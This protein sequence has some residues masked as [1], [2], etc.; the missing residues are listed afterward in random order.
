MSAL[1]QYIELFTQHREAI[2]SHSTTAMNALRTKAL[3]VLQ[4]TTL[5]RKG[6]DDYEATDLEEVLSPDYGVN[7]NRVNFDA[8]PQHPFKCDVPNL[9]TCMSYFYNDIFHT[10]GVD[11]GDG[12]VV[13][14]LAQAAE[15]HPELLQKYYGTVAK[16][17]QPT[18]AL[19]TLLAQDGMLVYVPRG[20]EAKRTIQVVNIFNASQPILVP[21]RILVIVE[22]G[23]QAKMLMC[24][25]SQRLGV[26]YVDSQVV[27]IIAER[28]ASFD[29]YDM[30]ETGTE[31]RRLRSVFVKQAE[32]SNVLTD[33]ITLYNGYTRNDFYVDV[34]GEHAETHL[35]GMAIAAGNQH[36]D[37]HTLISHNAPRCHSNEMFKYVLDDS[38]VGA[39]A[40]RI[41]VKPGCPQ[42]EAYQGNRNICASPH[43]RMYTK[44][45]LEIYTD[46]VKC[47]HGSTIGQIDQEA[48]F[49]M[50]QRGISQEAAR[51]LLMQAFMADV[52]NSVRLEQLKDRLHMLVEKRF[53]GTLA[54]CS[55]CSAQGCGCH[56]G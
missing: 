20:V 40:G 55:E 24:D 2:E 15:T 50:Q 21:R 37:N 14:S 41:V 56:C 18:V 52:I 25:H 30:E 4:S 49:Y 33:T 9:S 36:I 43:A 6:S 8:D 34:D 38:A 29:Y 28:G 10:T 46:D 19:N 16:L 31:T 26:P 27:E 47:S 39:F 45:Q 13:C 44:P 48:M 32:G 53:D 11:A 22:E 17:D 5:P 23:A 12:V 1:T 54:L 51:R 35:M 42:I 7:I 3:E